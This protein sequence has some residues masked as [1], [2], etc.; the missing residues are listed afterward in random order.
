MN[1]GTGCSYE[2]SI[3]ES[4]SSIKKIAACGSTSMNCGKL[5]PVMFFISSIRLSDP[6]LRIGPNIS[7]PPFIRYFDNLIGIIHRNCIE[8]K[9]PMQVNVFL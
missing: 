9:L 1:Q 7:V 5:Q 8:R 2:C 4:F 6:G 3:S